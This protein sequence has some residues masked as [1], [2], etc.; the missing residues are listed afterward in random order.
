MRSL[1][2]TL[3]AWLAL[4]AGPLCA[5]ELHIATAANFAA[6]L[7]KLA[8]LFEQLRFFGIGR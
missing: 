7:Q 4:G 8:P 1:L 6:P 5:A 2:A 3:S